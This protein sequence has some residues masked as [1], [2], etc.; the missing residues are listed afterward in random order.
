MIHLGLIPTLSGLNMSYYRDMAEN[1]PVL[2]LAGLR[3]ELEVLT[4]N[5]AK[6]FKLDSKPSEPV[7]RLLSRLRDTGAITSD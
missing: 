2:S 7:G 4:R 5:P 6:G 3:I 1:D